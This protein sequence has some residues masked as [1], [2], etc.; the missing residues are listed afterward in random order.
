MRAKNTVTSLLAALALT[1][2]AG[3]NLTPAQ[4]LASP[5]P[6]GNVPSCIPNL[7]GVIEASEMQ[8][9]IG[10]PEHFLVS[11]AEGPVDL[12]GTTSQQKTTWDWSSTAN[13]DAGFDLI[14]SPLAG[15]W[16]A[17]TFPDGEFSAAIDAAH[18]TEGIYKVDNQ[19]V[20][21]L[22]VASTDANPSTGRVLLPYDAP[23]ALYRF[24]L[25][26][27]AA[28]V[29]HGTVTAGT[30][31]GSPYAGYDT[32]DVSVD[33]LGSLV[34]PDLTFTSALRIRTNVTIQPA[35]GFVSTRK[36][37]GFFFECFGEVAR[38]TS[39]LNETADDF[40]TASEIRRLGLPPQGS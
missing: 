37:D 8:P 7:D 28:W 35:Y 14:G 20:W 30:Y 6:T 12:A 36:L 9:A 18:T 4:P 29:S 2:C 34:L 16:Y 31:A 13:V 33:K 3:Q 38:A 40:T 1:G 5:T 22:G 39:K 27:G 19:A 23:V 26:V 25:M 21:L 24:P 10:V 32:Y 15:K 17:A 11:T